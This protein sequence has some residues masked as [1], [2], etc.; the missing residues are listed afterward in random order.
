MCP[1]HDEDDDS[2]EGQRKETLALCQLS[3]RK[4]KEAAICSASALVRQN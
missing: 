1:G 3:H 2:G 4:S